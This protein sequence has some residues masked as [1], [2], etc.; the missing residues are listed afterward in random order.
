LWR[1][2]LPH[3]FPTPQAASGVPMERFRNPVLLVAVAG[4][5][6]GSDDTETVTVERTTTATTAETPPE[7]TAT[8]SSEYIRCDENIEAKSPTTSCEFAQNVF[9]SR[10]PPR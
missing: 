7:R 1:V 4:G 8:T 9:W 5:C 10:V 6:G 2:S 3:Y